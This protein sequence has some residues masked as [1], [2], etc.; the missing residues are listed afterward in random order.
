MVL[1]KPQ[2]FD[3]TCGAADEAF[4]GQI[5][6]HTLTY[7]NQFPTDASK[8]VF[9]VSFMRDYAATWSQPYQQGLPLGTSGL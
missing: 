5:C 1:A 7:P 8:V 2:H 3:G 6:L 4:V 9:T